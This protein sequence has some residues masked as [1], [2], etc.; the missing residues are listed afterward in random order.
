MKVRSRIYNWSRF[1]GSPF[2]SVRESSAQV[3]TRGKR[4]SP[5]PGEHGALW[6]EGERFQV[7]G[8]GDWAPGPRPRS[9]R[10]LMDERFWHSFTSIHPQG[11]S[12]CQG[13]PSVGNF[14]LWYVQSGG[15]IVTL[16]CIGYNFT[17]KFSI[18]K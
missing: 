2:C 3:E 7:V 8:T 16:C 6:K 14:L 5:V 17:P 1:H 18:M 11:I 12:S 13:T 4:G 10:R 15:N 9:A